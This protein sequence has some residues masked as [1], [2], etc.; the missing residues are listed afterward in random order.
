VNLRPEFGFYEKFRESWA[1]RRMGEVIKKELT[2]AMLDSSFLDF[3]KRKV[4]VQKSV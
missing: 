4:P 2:E 3:L 1:P